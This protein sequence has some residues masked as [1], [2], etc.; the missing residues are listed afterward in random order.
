MS[1]F[2]FGVEY[3]GAPFSG[4]QMQENAPSVQGELERAFGIAL[5]RPIRVTG[6]GRTDAGVHA[7]GQV[8]HFDF[9]GEIDPERL[10]RSVNALTGRYIRVRRLERC[11]PE[12]HARYSALS[13][14]YLYRIALR[15]VALLQD[16]S[17]HPGFLMDLNLFTSELRSAIGD[18]D[19]SN[20]SVP[21]NDGKSTRCH[22]I[23][24]E[25]SREG[26]FFLIRVE[27]NRFL[28]KMVRSLV[29]AGFD[30]ARGAHE[31]GLTVAILE[32]RFR[33]S[34]MWAPPQGL[35]LEKVTY[36]DYDV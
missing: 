27:A 6:A 11:A 18:R 32:G 9:D 12:F 35:C 28:H 5:R 10:T 33:G 15:P 2:R 19:F 30:V 26:D 23:R 21:R 3:F 16:L 4:W 14:A 25:T 29:G 13:R 7:T 1:R 36:P 31:P 20:F 34:R 8:V 24:V 22:L 17:W